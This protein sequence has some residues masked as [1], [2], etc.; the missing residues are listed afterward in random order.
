MPAAQ[1]RAVFTPATPV[2]ACWPCTGPAGVAAAK[3]DRNLFDADAIELFAMFNGSTPAARPL[4][5]ADGARCPTKSIGETASWSAPGSRFA[6]V[7]QGVGG[8]PDGARIASA[9][10]V[11]SG[12]R[13][14]SGT[15]T[16]ISDAWRRVQ[17][18]LGRI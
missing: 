2:D 14:G 7:A 15:S 5:P 17:V 6:D 3:T 10:D 11:A 12:P 13:S 16:L 1:V 8:V 4:W 9:L 18:P